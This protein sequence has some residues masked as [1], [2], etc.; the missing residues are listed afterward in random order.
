VIQI[1]QHLMRVWDDVD[2]RWAIDEIA[3]RREFF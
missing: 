1:T 3:Q 2:R